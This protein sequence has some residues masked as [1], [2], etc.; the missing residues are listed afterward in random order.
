MQKSKEQK[1]L[2]L[3]LF[4][5]LFFF[6][7][8]LVLLHPSSFIIHPFLSAFCAQSGSRP[9]RGTAQLGKQTLYLSDAFRQCASRSRPSS[10][11]L[12]IVVSS[13]PFLTL[14]Q[15]AL[16]ISRC[17][18]ASLFMEAIARRGVCWERLFVAPLF[19]SRVNR[20]SIL[21]LR[22]PLRLPKEGYGWTLFRVRSPAG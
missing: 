1:V 2:R 5:I 15:R 4:F 10:L 21:A 11:A 22:T 20:I 17:P 3:S 12:S 8:E 6:F 7:F 19:S 13:P 9:D 18:K 14:G 16:H